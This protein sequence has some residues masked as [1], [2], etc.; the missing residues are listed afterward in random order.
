MRYFR[1]KINRG[2]SQ[3]DKMTSRKTAKPKNSMLPILNNQENSSFTNLN[4]CG[5][6]ED[7][8]RKIN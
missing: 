3:N 1:G 7:F 2:W 4:L 6:M 5:G 8:G